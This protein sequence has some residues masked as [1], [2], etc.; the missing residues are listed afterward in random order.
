M[1]YFLTE[2]SENDLLNVTTD[3]RE[4]LPKNS[5]ALESAIPITE[6]ALPNNN[7]EQADTEEPV[8]ELPEGGENAD[9]EEPGTEGEGETPT[10]TSNPMTTYIIIG[11]IAVLGIG[12]GYY[13]KVVKGKKEQ[14]I[15]EDE[16]EEE[17]I[18]EEEENE[19]SEDDFFDQSDEEE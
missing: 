4:T 17:E 11:V 15:D 6:G 7:G 1:V 8:E 2:I 5:A 9:T 3:N 10:Q 12:G 16:D 19:D 18:Y 13:F 14:F